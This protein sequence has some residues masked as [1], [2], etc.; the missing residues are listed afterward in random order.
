MQRA[1]DN[2]LK[3]VS[4]MGRACLHC[5]YSRNLAALEFHHRDRSNKD[6]QLDAR[7]LANRKWTDIVAEAAKCDLLCSNC[8]AEEHNPNWTLAPSGAT[9]R[10]TAEPGND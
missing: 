3:L 9:P 8:H 5:G 7:T 10:T 2:K 4:V 6:F 1:R